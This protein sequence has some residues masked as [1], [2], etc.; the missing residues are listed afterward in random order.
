MTSFLP[1]SVLVWGWG[2]VGIRNDSTYR[3]ATTLKLHTK[4][5][6][7]ANIFPAAGIKSVPLAG[8]PTP[9]NHL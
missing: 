6:D 5:S 8:L 9:T 7:H 2:V 3:G 4:F 1:H